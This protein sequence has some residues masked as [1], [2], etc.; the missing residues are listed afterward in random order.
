M[1]NRLRQIIERRRLKKLSKENVKPFT[2]EHQTVTALICDVYDG[3]T[4]TAIIGLHRTYY[5]FKI[6][7][8][9]I[10][11]PEIRTKDPEEKRRGYQARDFVR[12]HILDEIVTIECFPF[13]KYGRILGNVWHNGVCINELLLNNG[14]A[15]KY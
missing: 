11:T 13:D 3:D 1:M 2:F 6:R 10:D 12:K 4:I 9:G 5:K 7:L 8:F 15:R 14:M